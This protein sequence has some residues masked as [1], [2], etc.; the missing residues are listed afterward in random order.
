MDATDRIIVATLAEDGRATLA[1]LSTAT[2][3]ST[4]AVQARVQRL[5]QSKVIRGYRAIVDPD[6][7]G[8]RLTAFVEIAPLDPADPDDAPVRLRDV[9]GVEACY[10]VAG[11][12]NYLLLVRVDATATLEDLLK[13]I[14]A[15]ANV[16]TRTMVVLRTYFDAKPV[17]P[18]DTLS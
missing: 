10:S 3:L 14:R 6:A 17:P 15:R 4:S 16:S 12:A 9:R 11:D 5:E 7:L 2:G 18:A 13:A 1:K 8:L